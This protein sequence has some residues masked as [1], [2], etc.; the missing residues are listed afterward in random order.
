MRQGDPVGPRE[1]QGGP[2]RTQR[3]G[4]VV[5]DNKEA[6]KG[7]Q[8]QVLVS[9]TVQG[10]EAASKRHVTHVMAAT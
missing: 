9:I 4:L 5:S 10:S 7:P 6:L 2:E 3:T 1:A 8:K